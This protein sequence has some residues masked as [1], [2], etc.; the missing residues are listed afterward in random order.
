MKDQL[1]QFKDYGDA[2]I[3]IEFSKVY[4]KDAWQKAHYL[5]H[6]IRARKIKGILGVIPTYSTLFIN[7]DYLIIKRCEI[8][9]L[10]KE[11]LQSDIGKMAD[12]PG[13]IFR[14][15]VLF[16]SKWGPDLQYV[17]ECLKLSEEQTIKQFCSSPLPII[18]VNRGPM[19][20]SNF[21]NDVSRL[22][23]PRTRVPAGAITAAGSQVSIMTQE[24]PGGW[25]IL[26]QTPVKMNI[27]YNSDPPVPYK[28]GDMMEFFEI[29][30][31]EFIKYNGKTV[32]EM[33]VS[34]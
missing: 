16:G 34:E 4:T 32:S 19:F 24:S 20:G 7:Y 26:G 2:G 12:V 9:E 30:E 28:P 3:L 18:C 15:P 10:I 14:I 5:A 13:R 6:Q 8:Y 22:E 1:F 25:R 27:D 29:G 33:K 17:S 23:T 11:W 31:D 21:N